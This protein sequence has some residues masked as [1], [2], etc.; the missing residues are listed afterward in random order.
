VPGAAAF[1]AEA[2]RRAVIDPLVLGLSTK[3]RIVEYVLGA[4]KV[5]ESFR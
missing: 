1:R 5:L 4:K 2:A 3:I